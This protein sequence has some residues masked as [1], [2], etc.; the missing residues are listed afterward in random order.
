MGPAQCAGG[1]LRAEAA[2]R[3]HG[4][5]GRCRDGGAATAVCLRGT[6]GVLGVR[7]VD[8]A[9]A[10]TDIATDEVR[11]WPFLV[12]AVSVCGQVDAAGAAARIVE[13]LSAAIA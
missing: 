1:R 11:K 10:G 2:A 4:E 6:A 12:L 9:K 7:D 13:E 8:H 5:G 3:R